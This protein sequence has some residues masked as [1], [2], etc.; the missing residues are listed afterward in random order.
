MTAL[1]PERRSTR[2]V[3]KITRKRIDTALE[4][5]KKT[6]PRGEAVHEARKSLKK[7]R[8]GLR[9][10]RPGVKQSIYRRENAA[11]RD[12]AQPLSAV[13]DAQVL[14][15]TLTALLTRYGAPARA[16]KLQGLK[17]TITRHRNSTHHALLQPPAALAHSR[18]L[19]R[20]ARARI[21]TLT[22]HQHDW[23]VLGVGLQ[24]VYAQSRRALTG[25]HDRPSA[26]HFHE[27]RKQVKYLRYELA[28]LEPMWPALISTL[29]DQAHRLTDYLGEDHDLTVLREMALAHRSELSD[30][31]L[32][33]LLALIDRRQGQLRKKAMLLGARLFEEK[34]KHF[35]ARFGQYWRQW[36]KALA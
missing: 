12:A 32:E 17:R 20:N 25:V 5:L 23:S 21:T 6:H 29:M 28:I 19:L 31:A 33:A 16:L 7:A 8:A 11:L 9:L 26:E 1:S 3:L 34:P 35:V 30:G 18:S 14:N 15:P 24:R 2:T 10:L 13:R 36:R 27:W 4:V 22:I